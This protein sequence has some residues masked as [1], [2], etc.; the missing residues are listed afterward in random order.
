MTDCVTRPEPQTIQR[1]PSASCP[2]CRAMRQHVDAEWV[3]FHPDA[4]HGFQ[5]DRGWTKPG[6]EGNR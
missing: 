6:L 3:Q 5:Q 4:G 2:A 1:T